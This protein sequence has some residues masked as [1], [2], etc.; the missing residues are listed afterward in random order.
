M[1]VDKWEQRIK[2][3]GVL[4]QFDVALHAAADAQ[5]DSDTEE[6]DI[7]RIERILQ[8][9]SQTL[10]AADPVV[11]SESSL[12]I[13]KQ[14]VVGIGAYL[15]RFRSERSPNLI[16][17]AL[18]QAEGMLAH[19][20]VFRT[21]GSVAEAAEVLAGFRRS[22]G[23]HRGYIERDLTEVL[24]S[25]R[26]Q[27]TALAGQVAEGTARLE[28]LQATVSQLELQANEAI[29]RQQT[30][31]AE[32]QDI[33]STTFSTQLDAMSE[34][35]RADQSER[36]ATIASHIDE[37]RASAASALD[38]ASAALVTTVDRAKASNIRIDE[39]L[40]LVGDKALVGEYG[41][42]ADRERKSANW[43]R[44]LAITALLG[45]VGVGIWAAVHAVTGNWHALAA[46]ALLAASIAGL[47]AYLARQSSEHRQAE[48][49]ARHVGLQLKALK[50]YLSDLA[51]VS[52]RDALL[53]EFAPRIFGQPRALGSSEDDPELPVSMGQLVALL[54]QILPR[55]GK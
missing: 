19:L 51:E 30:T 22:I 40:G 48:R 12:N 32:A 4:E 37:F 44:G 17:E 36:T 31:F 42:T 24:D 23:Q 20:P 8:L 21:V 11:A 10:Y 16:A 45:A 29:N 49:E 53:K 14:L 34:S 35:F 41:Q 18:N 15:D 46:K 6:A 27:V 25:A 13:L 54:V 2:T 52:D 28:R 5:S 38:E 7:R 47:A 55:L 50:P 1:T 33:R 9:A 39:I 43:L 26:A 3:D